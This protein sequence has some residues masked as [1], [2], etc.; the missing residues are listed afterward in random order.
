[1]HVS[2]TQ[3]S[4]A[5]VSKT[6][7]T[8]T[9]QRD[10]TSFSE[11]FEKV[12]STQDAQRSEVA[13]SSKTNEE[14][15]AEYRAKPG[16]DGY[17][18]EGMYEE[19]VAN[20]T[21][22]YET[23]FQRTY[24]FYEKYKDIF[25]PKYSN[26]T[27]QK[28]DSIAR[29]LNAQF[30]DYKAV[31]FQAYHGGSEADMERFN[32]MLLDYQ[33]FNKYLHEKYDLD[34]GP[35]MSSYTPE[36]ARAY[37]FAVYDQLEKGVSIQ[38]ARKNA[39][40]IAVTFGG[41][42]SMAFEMMGFMGYPESMEEAMQTPEADK[43]IDYDRQIDLR[44]KGIEHNFA[45]TNYDLLFGTD[46][47][48]IKQRIAYQ[49]DLFQYLTVHEGVVD[50]K[51]G[52]LKERSPEWFEFA[53]SNGDYAKNLKTEFKKAVEVAK[54]A[55]EIFD[56]YADRI[57]QKEEPAARISTEALLT[58]K[59]TSTQGIGTQPKSPLEKALQQSA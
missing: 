10:S 26:Y 43:E 8:P 4:A 44:D 7:N 9:A 22:K 29:E 59:Q 12:S 15:I 52:E 41:G 11:E 6:A 5:T 16:G 21:A 40:A 33:A 38:E 36:G 53:N 30:P 37:N 34:M 48:G 45:F 25:T 57:F 42:E 39:D 2:T 55:K 23:E 19:R 32:D 54:M 58:S 28:A 35:G 56:K 1:M 17:L 24:E 18:A 3:T 46:K 14:I 31:Q 49:L 50:Q 13:K 20:L 51:I 47:E 27:R